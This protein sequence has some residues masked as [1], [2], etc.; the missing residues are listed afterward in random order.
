M[1]NGHVYNCANRRIWQVYGRADRRERG[2]QRVKLNHNATPL[3]MLNKCLDKSSGV[4]YMHDGKFSLMKSIYT[5]RQKK[6]ITSSE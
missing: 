1:N 3:E 2:K 4:I 6:L 5:E